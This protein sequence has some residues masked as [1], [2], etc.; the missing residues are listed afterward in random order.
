MATGTPEEIAACLA[1]H[2]GRYLRPLLE[3][4]AQAVVQAAEPAKR[5][6]K[7]EKAGV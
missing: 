4:D 5:A 3:R 2:T 7:R 1:S 6:R